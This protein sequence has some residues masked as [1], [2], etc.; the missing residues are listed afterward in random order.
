MTKPQRIWSWSFNKWEEGWGGW[1]RQEHLAPMCD[2]ERETG[3]EY[4]RI[5]LFK[6]QQ[7]KLKEAE[8]IINW[9]LMDMYAMDNFHG[10]I[11][12]LAEKF[13]KEQEVD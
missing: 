11:V 9:F 8:G 6:S 5:D 1:S 2:K 4:V 13:L 12:Q 7:D 3:S 10:P